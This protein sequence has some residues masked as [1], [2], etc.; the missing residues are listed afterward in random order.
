[1]KIVVSRVLLLVAGRP[2]QGGLC[3]WRLAFYGA[4]EQPSHARLRF[5]KPADL[6]FSLA[7]H[8][9]ALLPSLTR[10]AAFR[11]RRKR[12]AR[13]QQRAQARRSLV[14]LL[15]AAAIARGTALTRT[16]SQLVAHDRHLTGDLVR[17]LRSGAAN[18]Q[19]TLFPFAFGWIVC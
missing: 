16:P 10:L 17:G 6:S 12:Q 7:L 5:P 15:I 4:C 9:S 11:L 1:M 3:A 8:A 18:R 13:V 2:R 19:S 14:V